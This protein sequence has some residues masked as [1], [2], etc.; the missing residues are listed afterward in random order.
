M[1]LSQFSHRTT[2]HTGML[3]EDYSMKKWGVL[4]GDYSFNDAQG[5][6][7]GFSRDCNGDPKGM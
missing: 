4:T 1:A 6:Q 3:T 7:L 5:K 2:V